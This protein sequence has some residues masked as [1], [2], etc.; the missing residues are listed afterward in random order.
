M[1]CVPR[2]HRGKVN[3]IDSVRTFS[4]SGSAALGGLLIERYGF[5]T[6]FLITAA[7]KTAAFVPLVAL[8]AYVP[9][10]L[11]LPAGSRYR[12]L[13]RRQQWQRAEAQAAAG[14]SGTG[15]GG[16][17]DGLTRPLLPESNGSGG[18]GDRAGGGSVS[19]RGY[20]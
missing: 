4:W 16:H 14:A 8:L 19:G 13:R 2:Q 5:Q 10:G 1:D 11:C 9:D 12:R 6:T 20:A 17:E 18:G 3:A 7:I 15:D